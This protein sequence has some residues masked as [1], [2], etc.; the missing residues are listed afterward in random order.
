MVFGDGAA[1]VEFCWRAN[2]GRGSDIG[3][4]DDD[5]PEFLALVDDDSLMTADSAPDRLT[6]RFSG[7]S[8]KSGVPGRLPLP[9][10]PP[11]SLSWPLPPLP[12]TAAAELFWSD[13]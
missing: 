7:F 9:P 10:P 4:E 2:R 11:L 13:L 6:R 3:S 5:E 8:S 1:W 12:T